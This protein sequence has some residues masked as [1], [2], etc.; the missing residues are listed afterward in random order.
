MSG[1]PL[2][3]LDLRTSPRHLGSHGRQVWQFQCRCGGVLDRMAALS[4]R[5]VARDNTFVVWP[6]PSL[7]RTRPRTTPVRKSRRLDRGEEGCGSDRG[8]ERPA[9]RFPIVDALN[10]EWDRLAP[11]RGTS[12]PWARTH[13]VLATYADLHDVLGAITRQPDAALGAL[14][15]KVRRGDVLGGSNGAPC[16]PPATPRRRRRNGVRAPWQQVSA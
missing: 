10:D 6:T 11:D 7:S 2:S 1:R 9:S 16:L 15:T 4:A 13:E 8:I 5:P 12:A 3:R 14:L